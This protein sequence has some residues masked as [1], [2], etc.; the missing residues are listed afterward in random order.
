[1]RLTKVEYEFFDF[2]E[3]SAAA[4]ELA[5]QIL[6]HFTDAPTLFVSWTWERQHSSDDQP[7]S[8]G[9]SA[10][11]YFKDEPAAVADASSTP[12][13]LRHLGRK[14]EVSYQPT[15]S[16]VFE[17]QVIVVRSSGDPTFVFSLGLDRVGVSNASP[18]PQSCSIPS[19][20]SCS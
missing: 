16:P 13:W 10:S 3:P 15:A 17:Y 9:Q 18:I 11:S 8:I 6:L 7:Y 4:N 14:V 5:R 2:E 12:Q 1:M 20:D 19:I